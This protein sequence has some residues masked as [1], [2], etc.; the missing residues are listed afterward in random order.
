[1]SVE[2]WNQLAEKGS[3]VL[4]E[5]QHRRLERYLELLAEANTRMNLT[6]IVDKE[7]A[8]VAHV[9]DALTL[10]PFVPPAQGQLRIVDVGSGGGVPGIPLAVALPECQITLVE[11]TQ[12]KAVFLQSCAK[13]LGLSNVTVLAKRAEEVASGAMRE[14]H[15]VVTARAVGELA[16]L[17]EWGI[18]LLKKGGKLLAMKGAKAQEEIVGADRAIKLLNASAAVVHP[19]E[20]PGAEHHVIVEIT[21]M[22]RTDARY[23]RAATVAKG[24]PL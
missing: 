7:Q 23:P 15:D 6:R 17:V 11:A 13:E 18:P 16:F 3:R 2:L 5:E 12:K 1:M 4:S 24:K 21:K 20:L 19:V 8:R 22:G 10:L 14:S 9:G